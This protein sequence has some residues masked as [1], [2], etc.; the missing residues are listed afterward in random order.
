MLLNNDNENESALTLIGNLLVTMKWMLI[1]LNTRLCFALR[2]AKNA[3]CQLICIDLT[4]NAI[5]SSLRNT[6][7]LKIFPRKH[8][9]FLLWT[10]NFMPCYY[11]KKSPWTDSTFTVSLF[12]VRICF[13]LMC[14]FPT[15]DVYCGLSQ[16]RLHIIGNKDSSAQISRQDVFR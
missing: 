3:G 1:K 12:S 11:I 5:T 15:G 16:G 13:S 8:F 7:S 9:N 14:S 10:C 4:P 6:I 2:N